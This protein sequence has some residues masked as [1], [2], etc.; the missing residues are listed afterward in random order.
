MVFDF[1][2]KDML[3]VIKI[4]ETTI[5]GG[6]ILKGLPVPSKM[7]ALIKR[8]SEAETDIKHSK[9]A[10]ENL[11]LVTEKEEM[12]RKIQ[13][14][15]MKIDTLEN[16]NQALEK[17]Y[18]MAT[19]SYPIPPSPRFTSA[20]TNFEQS[21]RDFEEENIEEEQAEEEDVEEVSDTSKKSLVIDCATR[22]DKEFMKEM[23]GEEVRMEDLKKMGIDHVKRES[24]VLK[25]FIEE[26]SPEKT[27]MIVFNS[28]EKINGKAE[29]ERELIEVDY[30]LDSLRI[31][32]PSATKMIFLNRL[33]IKDRP[34]RKIMQASAF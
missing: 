7:N 27:G 1:F 5:S 4:P 34:L 31:L 11:D 15:K 16:H 22:E 17:K 12:L 14:M 30:Y 23:I 29:K 13:L 6:D 18:N 25:K 3:E 32:L 28:G 9:L 10:K 33:I 21:N 8:A 19:T 26:C 20:T 24:K 2:M